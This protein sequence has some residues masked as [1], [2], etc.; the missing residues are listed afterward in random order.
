MQPEL[1]RDTFH[2]KGR[3]GIHPPKTGLARVPDALLQ[4]IGIVKLRQ[5]SIEEAARLHSIPTSGL[6]MICFISNTE[7]IGSRRMKIKNNMRN[8]AIVP[9][10][11]ET[12]QIVG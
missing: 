2:R 1:F 10:N 9:R 11:V 4:R 8:S 6:S 12:S 3:V 7:I 5:E